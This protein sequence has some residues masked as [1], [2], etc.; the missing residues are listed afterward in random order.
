MHINN[1]HIITV[2]IST[3]VIVMYYGLTI[4]RWRLVVN[5]CLSLLIVDQSPSPLPF[6]TTYIMLSTPVIKRCKSSRL[7]DWM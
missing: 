7:Y 3:I 1:Q 2:D 5:Y 6:E 4:N